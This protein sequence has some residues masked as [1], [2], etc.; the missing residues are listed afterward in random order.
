MFSAADDADDADVAVDPMIGRFKMESSHMV[1]IF[2]L[3]FQ[4]FDTFC[5]TV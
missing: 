5:N 1:N 2:I 3:L 4:I